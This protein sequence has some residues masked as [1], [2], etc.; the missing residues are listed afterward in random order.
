[1]APAA[2]VGLTAARAVT[3]A[4]RETAG[5]PMAANNRR[6]RPKHNNCPTLA[7]GTVWSIVI[8]YLY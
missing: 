7:P 6:C 4:E 8:G 3:V 1:M 5:A 2:L